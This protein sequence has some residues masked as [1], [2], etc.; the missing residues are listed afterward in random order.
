[1]PHWSRR[2]CQY[3]TKDATATGNRLNREG[4]KGAKSA[5]KHSKEEKENLLLSSAAFASLR[6]LR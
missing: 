2:I 4:A 3:R 6:P 5:K 1:L